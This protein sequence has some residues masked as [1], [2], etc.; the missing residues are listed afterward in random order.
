MLTHSV[1]VVV[2]QVVFFGSAVGCISC[3][4]SGLQRRLVTQAEQLEVARNLQ[5]NLRRDLHRATRDRKAL[6]AQQKRLG[7]ALRQAT[8][9][10]SVAKY[11]TV[12]CRRSLKALGA[13]QRRAIRPTEHVAFQE[14]LI[15]GG[16][17]T[18]TLGRLFLATRRRLAACYVAHI[19]GSGKGA[20]AVLRVNYQVT[21]RGIRRVKFHRASRGQRS[22]RRCVAQVIRT[23]ALPRPKR[24]WRVSQ[25]IAFGPRRH[26]AVNAPYTAYKFPWPLPRKYRAGPGQLCGLGSRHRKQLKQKQRLNPFLARPCAAGLT[27]CGGCGVPGCDSTCRRGPCPK[28]P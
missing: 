14:T 19:S 24:P 16:T 5:T 2:G 26:L 15:W 20:V 17:A 3:A 11:N 12:T 27:C 1:R 9:R 6:L 18:P 13:P 23:Q 22:L 10:L 4:Q 28:L 21:S 7:Q 25:A 8:S